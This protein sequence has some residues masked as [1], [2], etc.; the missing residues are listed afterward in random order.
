MTLVMN[1]A[2]NHINTIAPDDIIILAGQSNMAG[3]GL[4]EQ[5][6]PI[7]DDGILMWRDG[8]WV[9]A[10]EPLHQD[11]PRAGI[12]LGMSLAAELRKQR[13]QRVIGLV[14]TAVGGSPIARWRRA[15]HGGD[16]YPQALEIC[17]AA[18]SAAKNAAKS[19]AMEAGG[20]LLALAWHQGE[21]DSNHEEDAAIWGSRLAEM[22][23]AWREDL[24]VANLP[25]V[26]G[27]LG[28]YLT[29]Q[30]DDPERFCLPYWQSINAHL[31]QLELPHFAVVSGQGLTTNPDLLHMDAAALRTFGQRYAAALLELLD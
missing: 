31:H 29:D 23:N 18:I 9:P 10:V 5:V 16:L 15:E 24:G 27:E 28:D 19:G 26:A 14:A 7:V 2:L 8:S 13:P 20:N 11:R 3:R 21:G 22:F 17:R 1:A 6:D 4:L 25:I 12:G 30:A